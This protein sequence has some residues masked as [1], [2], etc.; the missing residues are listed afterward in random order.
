MTSESLLSSSEKEKGGAHE[1]CGRGHTLKKK[2]RRKISRDLTVSIMN[3]ITFTAE[4]GF[5][6][7]G[8]K[9]AYHPQRDALEYPLAA[10]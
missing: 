4:S 6:S 2:E 8:S 7:L 3:V 5:T 1:A 9:V 10:V